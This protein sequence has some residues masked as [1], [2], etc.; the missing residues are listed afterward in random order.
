M[1]GEVWVG[2]LKR[3][4]RRSH[5]LAGVNS[6]FFP[7]T[8]TIVDDSATS[9][10]PR[11]GGHSSGLPYGKCLQTNRYVLRVG[12]ERDAVVQTLAADAWYSGTCAF[13]TAEIPLVHEVFLFGSRHKNWVMAIMV[14][15]KW[16][17]VTRVVH[18]FSYVGPHTENFRLLGF[19]WRNAEWASQ[20]TSPEVGLLVLGFALMSIQPYAAWRLKRSYSPVISMILAYTMLLVGSILVGCGLIIL[21]A[22]LFFLAFIGPSFLFLSGLILFI[23]S[24]IPIVLVHP[25]RGNRQTIRL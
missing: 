4:S 22:Y 10:L 9:S 12:D 13:D 6:C 16:V 14:D 2:S 20:I 18:E 19:C 1:Y 23:L 7:W 8:A 11:R 24:R 17:N 3:H 25:L 5:H 15:S 21:N